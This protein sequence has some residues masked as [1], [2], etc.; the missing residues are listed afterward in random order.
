MEVNGPQV[1]KRSESE[2]RGVENPQVSFAY[3]WAVYFHRSGHYFDQ[4]VKV[5]VCKSASLCSS[6]VAISTLVH[7][8]LIQ[9]MPHFL[10][11]LG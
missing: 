9:P 10:M 6:D 3:L 8:M 4:K 2:S 11:M 5:E 1:Y 7:R